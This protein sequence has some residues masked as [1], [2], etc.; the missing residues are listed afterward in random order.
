MS[1][2]NSLNSIHKFKD[3]IKYQTFIDIYNICLNQIKTDN[4]AY[5]QETLFEIP[6][7]LPGKMTYEFKDCYRFINTLL[8]NEGF[9]T[10]YIPPC[11][12]FI[13]W[14]D[15]TINIEDH[16]GNNLE[17]INRPKYNTKNKKYK[18]DRTDLETLSTLMNY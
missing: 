12:I 5:K 14:K 8:K 17:E 2:I 13:S 18:F 7:F 10:R 6:L 11:N 16:V 15:I 3:D 1:L 9:I 4:Y